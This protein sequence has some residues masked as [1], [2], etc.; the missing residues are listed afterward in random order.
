M[1]LDAPARRRSR[2]ATSPLR[3]VFEPDDAWLA[4]GDL[5][6]RD[7]DGDYWLVDHVA[8]LIRTA[9]GYVAGVPDPAT[10]SATSTRSTSPSSTAFPS[11]AEDDRLAIA[12]V[13]AARGPRARRRD[14]RRARSTSIAADERPD[15]VRRRRRDPG[16]HLV[17]PDRDRTPSRGHAEAGRE[18]MA[19]RRRRLRPAW[20][21]VEAGGRRPELSYSILALKD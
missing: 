16:D 2:P 19:P 3:G 4:T 20:S 15:I 10:R 13:T 5:F 21:G 17:S 1:L 9:H 8:A 11:R 6:R 14:G 18:D 7:E 12:A